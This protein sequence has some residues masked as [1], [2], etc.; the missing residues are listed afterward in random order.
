MRARYGVQINV[1]DYSAKAVD[2]KRKV[3]EVVNICEKRLVGA[4]CAVKTR[5]RRV[6]ELCA[7]LAET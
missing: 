6:E 2:C 5:T 4:G 1:A 3:S 7:P